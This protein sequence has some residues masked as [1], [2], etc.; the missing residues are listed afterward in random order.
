[1]RKTAVPSEKCDET[2]E[3]GKHVK[4]CSEVPVQCPECNRYLAHK[5]SLKDHMLI[6][7]GQK[8]FKCCLCVLTFRQNSQ[9]K[10]HMERHH[11]V[12]A[13]VKEYTCAKCGKE[14]VQNHTLQ[15]HMLLAHSSGGRF[16]C[17]KC[18]VRFSDEASLSKHERVHNEGLQCSECGKRFKHKRSLGR[19]MMMHNTE[20]VFSANDVEKMYRTT[21]EKKPDRIMFKCDKCD[22]AFSMENQLMRHVTAKHSGEKP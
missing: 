7:S 6:H 11:M 1:M 20:K 16:Q 19:H 22:R 2:E 14:F 15:K 5:S 3:Q 10:R 21:A 8:P 17:E 4:L 18:D 12:S 9:L 13:T